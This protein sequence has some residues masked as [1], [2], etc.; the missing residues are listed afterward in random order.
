MN[1]DK[2]EDKVKDEIT[3]VC[4]Q[5]GKNMGHEWLLGCVCGACCRKNHK[6]ITRGR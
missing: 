2:T 4:Q 5:C 3:H 1:K 6:K